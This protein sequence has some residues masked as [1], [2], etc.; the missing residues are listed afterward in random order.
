M[1][2]AEIVVIA[3]VWAREDQLDRLLELLRR[4]VELT[5][6]TEPHVLKFALHRDVDDPLHFAMVEA[7]P[8]EE[9]LLAHRA[10]DFYQELMAEIPDLIVKRTRLVTEPVP[11]GDPERGRIA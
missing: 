6:E 7:F 1:T 8:N 5:H 2:P 3:E 10:T 9:A 11:M 4:D